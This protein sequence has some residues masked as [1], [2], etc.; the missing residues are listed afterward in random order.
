[1]P[2]LHLAAIAASL[3]VLSMAAQPSDLTAK[4]T[5]KIE[6]ALK[7][8]GAPS[9]SVAV[10]ADGHLLF[11]KAFGS[12]DL[13]KGKSADVQTRYAVGSISK[14]FTAAALLLL[15]EQGKLSLDDRVAKYFPELTRAKEITIR[16]LL[17]HTSGYEDF[18]PQD[19]IIPEWMQPTT[20]A[21]ILDRW[22][23]KPLNFDPGTKWQYSNTNYTLAGE[24]FE[25]VAGQP[26]VAFLREK[27]FDPLGMSSAGDCLS[28]SPVDA[29]AYTRYAVGPPRPAGREANGWYFAAGELCMTPSDLAKWDIAFLQKKILS[30]HSYEEFTREVKLNNGDLTHYALGL[31]LGDVGGM[32]TLQ[33]G[34]EV[35]GFISSNMILPTHNGAV[36]VLSN[37]DA[38][39]LVAPLSRQLAT[40]AFLPEQRQPSD[41]DTTQV[42]SILEG[43]RNGQIN[44]ALFTDNANSYFSET[45]LH[46]EKTSLAALGK[47][48]SVTAVSENLR[49]G[50]THRT[51]HAEYEKKTLLLNIYLM[52]DGKFEQFLVEDQL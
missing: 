52:P 4:L 42:R 9:V 51:Y 41:K 25:K 43:L 13:A 28:V 46:D 48:K 5:E 20:P 11:A 12:A 34:G 19:Y 1:M 33:H 50:M 21:A 15:Q 23:E 40:M 37:E 49:G 27:I 7:K 30:A 8:S 6:S 39:S 14:Q 31:T 3:S 29:V 22:A 38:I 47:L 32:P 24:I 45:A 36:I 18:A 26:L 10:V 35:S 44:R 2:R 17:S 16:Q